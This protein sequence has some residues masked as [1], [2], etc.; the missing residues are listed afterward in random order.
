MSV[1]AYHG[2]HDIDGQIVYAHLEIRSEVITEWLLDGD[3]KRGSVDEDLKT[4]VGVADLKIEAAITI[5]D[6]LLVSDVAREF[7]ADYL[8]WIL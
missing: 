1:F 5:S 3:A 7:A 4:V 6:F 8:A 2:S